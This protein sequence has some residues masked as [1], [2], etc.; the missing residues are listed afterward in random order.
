M[1]VETF[2]KLIKELRKEKDELTENL[3]LCKLSILNLKDYFHSAF[4]LLT[5]LRVL[6]TSSDVKAKENLQKLLFPKGIYYNKQN[7]PF[8]TKKI[9]L[10]FQQIAAVISLSANP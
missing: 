5:K 3:R 1:P 4:T 10:V 8:R 6:W 2:E 7:A 9:N